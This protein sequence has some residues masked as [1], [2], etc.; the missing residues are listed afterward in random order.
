MEEKHIVKDTHFNTVAI[1][2]HSTPG[3]PAAGFGVGID[4][5]ILFQADSSTTELRDIGRISFA[6]DIATNASR[7][8]VVIIEAVRDGR[9]VEV[10][11]INAN[12]EIVPVKETK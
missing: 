12:G 1:I 3:V 2:G 11:R 5:S 8:S 6:W 10:A 7:R 4:T 9:L